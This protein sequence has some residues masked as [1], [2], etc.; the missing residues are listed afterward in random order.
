MFPGHPPHL[1]SDLS[2]NLLGDR[3]SS[4]C[5][6]LEDRP[7]IAAAAAFKCVTFP[8]SRRR[9]SSLQPG[10]CPGLLV[11]SRVSMSPG[12]HPYRGDRP[13]LS[14]SSRLLLLRGRFLFLLRAY[15]FLPSFSLFLSRAYSISFFPERVFLSSEE[16]WEDC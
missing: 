8:L 13:T 11:R 9:E 16:E 14:H 6:A 2:P 12:T 4:P 10:I 7:V 1:L 15:T 5:L 3:P